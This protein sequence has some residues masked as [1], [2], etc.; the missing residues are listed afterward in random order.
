MRPQRSLEVVACAFSPMPIVAVARLDDAT[1]DPGG[2]VP[3]ADGRD[4]NVNSIV[5]LWLTFGGGV[6]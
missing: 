4:G 5:M 6:R 1:L 2:D 3:P